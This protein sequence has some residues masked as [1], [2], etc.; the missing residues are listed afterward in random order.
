MAN[1][2]MKYLSLI[3]TF[4]VLAIN[5]ISALDEKW[6]KKQLLAK[7]FYLNVVDGCIMANY[8]I[9]SVYHIRIMYGTCDTMICTRFAAKTHIKTLKTAF[10]ITRKPNGHQNSCCLQPAVKQWIFQKNTPKLCKFFQEPPDFCSFFT[11][12]SPACFK[13]I[14]K[15]GNIG[16]LWWKSSGILKFQN[17]R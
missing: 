3:N 15:H 17:E 6:F 16:T 4:Q 2:A 1:T 5:K 9:I 8:W 13:D 10:I 14:L 11:N 12:R 7:H